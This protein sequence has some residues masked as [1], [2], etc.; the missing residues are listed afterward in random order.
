MTKL[1]VSNLVTADGY[2]EGGPWEIDWHNVDAEFFAQADEM[3]KTLG[4]I[5]MGRKTY[6]GMLAYWT[7]EAAVKGDA[8]VAARMT[9]TP[10]IVISRTLKKAEWKNTTLVS[11]VSEIA[12]LKAKSDKDMVV[13]GS[14]DLCASL[15]DA[16]LLDEIRQ[17]VNPVLLGHG[18]PMFQGLR[19]KTKLKLLRT[20]TFANGNVMLVYEPEK[21]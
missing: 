5:L 14:S 21:T 11:E 7:S 15:L 17:I 1:Y 10:K 20:R 19:H 3:W 2:F 18:K 6:E 8:V 13:F 16:G 9:D 4:H 12:A